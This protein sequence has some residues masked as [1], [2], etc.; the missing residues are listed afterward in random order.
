MPPKSSKLCQSFTEV[1]RQTSSVLEYFVQYMESVNALHLVQFWLAVET[2]KVQSHSQ[3]RI[4]QLGENA[5]CL[6]SDSNRSSSVT[7]CSKCDTTEIGV[8]CPGTS[9]DAP[10]TVKADGETRNVGGSRHRHG[11]GLQ[12][13]DTENHKYCNCRIGMHQQSTPPLTPK[14]DSRAPLPPKHGLESGGIVNKDREYPSPRLKRSNPSADVLASL[15]LPPDVFTPTDGVST[16]CLPLGTRNLIPDM[17]SPKDQL[18]SNDLI[19]DANDL[20]PGLKDLP[21]PLTNQISDH[22]KSD[23][24][25]AYLS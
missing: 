13:R 5:R 10:G 22:V 15:N 23:L 18:G 1:M 19:P 11:G 2:F 16:K 12:R 3:P 24:H 20:P 17:L 6:N 9:K 14:Q 8:G 21:P 7:S 25:P 4:P